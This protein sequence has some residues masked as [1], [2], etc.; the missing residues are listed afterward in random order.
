VDLELARGKRR[1]KKD[2]ETTN[3]DA[4]I[5]EVAGGRAKGTKNKRF[6]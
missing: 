4:K 5:K 6:Y 2:E 1:L 3:N